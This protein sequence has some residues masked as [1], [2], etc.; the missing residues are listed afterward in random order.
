MMSPPDNTIRHNT[1]RFSLLISY[2]LL[3][4]NSSATATYDGTDGLKNNIFDPVCSYCHTTAYS[5]GNG[6][7]A[8]RQTAPEEVNFNTWT[9]INRTD[10]VYGH[11]PTRAVARAATAPQ[12][13]TADMPPTYAFSNYPTNTINFTLLSQTS[14]TLLSDWQAGGFLKNASPDATTNIQTDVTKTSATLNASIA[15]NGAETTVYFRH[16]TQGTPLSGEP[17]ISVTSPPG[18]GG[19]NDTKAINT[20]VSSLT[21]GTSYHFKIFAS[22]GIGGTQSGSTLSYSTDPCS[23]PVITDGTSSTELISVNESP[24]AFSLTLNAT[25]TDGGTLSW[26]VSTPVSGGSAS[27]SSPGSSSVISYDPPSS[28]YSGTDQFIVTVSDNTSPTAL[29][30]TYTVNVSIG[31]E[32]P[33]LSGSSTVT[34][35]EDNNPTAFSL[36]L[37]ATDPDTSDSLLSWDIS[38]PAGSGTA[39]VS[40]TG[41]SQSISYTPSLNLNGNAA[42][43]F[44]V[45]VQDPQFN[46]DTLIVTVNINPINDM[47]IA[48]IDNITLEAN[49]TNNTLNVLLND[50]DVD[51]ADTKR[52]T[53]IGTPSNGGSVS[54]NSPASINN[55]LNYTPLNDSQTP[56]TFTYTM[57]DA[58]G[59]QSIGTINIS[60]LDTDSDGLADTFDNCPLVS[61]N[62]QLDTDSDS[63]GDVCDNDPTGS[64]T[65]QTFIVFAIDQGGQNGSTVF[66]QDGNITVTADLDSTTGAG[67]IT[68]DW[69]QV[70]S[71][72]IATQVSL[73]GNTFVFDPSGLALGTYNI[74]VTIDDDGSTSHNTQIIN[75]YASTEPTLTA[76]D[77]D[78]D[79]INDDQP[80]EGFADDD[81]DGIPNYRDNNTELVNELSVNTNSSGSN[82]I[83]SAS[84]TKLSIGNTA[85]ASGIFAASITQ[86]T[87]AQFGNN[88]SAAQNTTDNSYTGTSEIFD[89]V[90]SNIPEIGA[91]VN[92][93]FPLSSSIRAD[94][95]Y[96]KYTV[97]NGWQDFVIDD[98]NK[99]SS[100]LSSAGICPSPG[101]TNYISGLNAFNN[102]MQLSIQDG[103]P[104]DDDAEI[105]GIIRDPGMLVVDAN[106]VITE[107]DPCEQSTYNSCNKNSG[108]IGVLNPLCFIFIVLPG[109]YR[110]IKPIIKD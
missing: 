29:T 4:N 21:C 97:A 70:D 77:T 100:A 17:D 80:A 26:S 45:R 105:N 50:T 18:T 3:S 96:R 89:F 34:M 99:I 36:T 108:G 60:F 74:G 33:S 20:I 25:D 63:L 110:I 39:S 5:T 55:T 66:Q 30:D 65:L 87:I 56:E 59:L 10:G 7:V 102:C 31:L 92:I 9:E 84:G 44:T 54:I 88:G 16:A 90:I 61:N 37:N 23:A 52:I 35:D 38:T 32:P 19:G 69:S 78:G 40:G 6:N 53:A 28:T 49:S 42:D 91:S 71:Q 109:L 68:H 72:L 94:S 85:I 14:Q 62:N 101:S 104:N 93:V 48:I 27:A 2:L 82:V 83:Q 57:Q 95:I 12:P 11:I 13:N 106:F 75:I 73:I 81:N 46:Q 41:A 98:A 8:N 1:V 51:T 67:V 58:A 22:N 76:I 43:S 64:G 107:A 103:G 24:N 47:P 79:G 15:E 86:E